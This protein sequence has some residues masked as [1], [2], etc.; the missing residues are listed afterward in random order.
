MMPSQ[1]VCAQPAHDDDDDDLMMNNWP[2]YLPR[3]DGALGVYSA[4]HQVEG[5][6]RVSGLQEGQ[7]GGH[8]EED[9][10][11]AHREGDAD[12]SQLEDRRRGLAGLAAAGGGFRLCQTD[13]KRPAKVPVVNFALK[14][15]Y[16]SPGSC[17]GCLGHRW[18]V[19][20]RRYFLMAGLSKT[21]K[22]YGTGT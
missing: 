1:I 10:P 2:N 7:D 18:Q 13:S 17:L 9:P 14:S 16:L 12:L 3:D 19:L 5:K 11:L 22:R 15:W 20:R 8:A 6:G 21:I 4:A